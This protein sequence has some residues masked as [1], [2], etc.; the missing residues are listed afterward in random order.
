MTNKSGSDSVK[1]IHA[2]A[3]LYSEKTNCKTDKSGEDI[4]DEL[5]LYS[6]SAKLHHHPARD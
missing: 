2:T 1:P 4:G 5:L 3:L 6:W